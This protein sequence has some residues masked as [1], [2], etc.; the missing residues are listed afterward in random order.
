MAKLLAKS[1][2]LPCVAGSD[3]HDFEHIGRVFN[4]VH[5]DNSIDEIIKAIKIGK[6][7]PTKIAINN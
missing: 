1:R 2:E 6:I 4:F 5:C 3:A 7:K